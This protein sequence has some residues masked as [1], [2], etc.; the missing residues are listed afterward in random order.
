MIA[1]NSISWRLMQEPQLRG[2]WVFGQGFFLYRYLLLLRCRYNRLIL[3]TD[4]H[5]QLEVRPLQNPW[6]ALPSIMFMILFQVWV[7]FRLGKIISCRCIQSEVRFGTEQWFFVVPNGLS[8]SS[9]VF[10]IKILLINNS[11]LLVVL[12]LQ[13]QFLTD[14]TIFS[15]TRDFLK[16]S[17][18]LF[19][20]SMR[21]KRWIC[22]VWFYFLFN[23]LYLL[24]NIFAF[25][26]FTGILQRV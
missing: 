8:A 21:I 11:A 14:L 26:L 15:T 16:Q 7:I 2:R 10:G 19:L 5:C 22:F 4:Q 24:S 17:V 20:I 25:H 9:Y 23:P 6:S 12:H 13:R 3:V 18:Q 1:V